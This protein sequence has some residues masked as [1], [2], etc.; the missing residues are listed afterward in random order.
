[1]PREKKVLPLLITRGA[2]V[3]PTTFSN[4][5]VGRLFSVSA[6]QK[7]LNETNSKIIVVAQKDISINEPTENDI[8]LY[9]Q[10]K[11]M[12]MKILLFLYILRF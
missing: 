10:L 9:S 6:M 3:F 11:K 1:M 8:S 5:D 4:I 2:V 12:K 7:S